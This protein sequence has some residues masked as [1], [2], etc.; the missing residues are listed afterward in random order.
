MSMS[1][2]TAVYCRLALKD[3]ERIEEQRQ[4]LSHF[5]AEQGH[6]NISA[7]IDNGVGG[8]SFNRLAFMKMDADI[9]AGKIDT[10]IVQSISR[11]G[12]DMCLV[13]NWLNKMQELGVQVK[14]VDGS[15]NEELN[16]PFNTLRNEIVRHCKKGA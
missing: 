14:T 16:L 13:M 5:V 8:H 11:I 3:D 2:L 6:Q 9:K 15:I 1:K 7:Y 4:V 12:R 10:V